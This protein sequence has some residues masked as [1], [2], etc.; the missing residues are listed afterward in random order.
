MLVSH[1]PSRFARW[2]RVGRAP[3][4]AAPSPD[5][6]F[7]EPRTDRSGVCSR[8]VRPRLRTPARRGCSMRV[9]AS[10]PT[11]RVTTAFRA[12]FRALAR[13]FAGVRIGFALGAGAARGFAHIGVLERITE[14]GLPIDAL[15]GLSA[16]AGIGCLWSFGYDGDR[17]EHLV[18]ELQ[19]HGVRWA[20]PTRSLLS[21]RRLER[22]LRHGAAGNGFDEARWPVG[23]VAVDMY[24]QRETLFTMGDLRGACSRAAPYP[25]SI[26]PS[27]STDAGT[28]TAVADPVPTLFVRPLGVDVVV[29]VDIGSAEAGGVAPRGGP[30]CWTSCA[31][32]RDSCTAASASTAAPAQTSSCVRR[33]PSERRGCSAT[34]EDE[35]G[36]VSDAT[37]S[38]LRRTRSGSFYC[39]APTPGTRAT[40]CGRARAPARDP[41][42]TIIRSALRP[43]SSLLRN[44][45][46]KR[47]LERLLEA[48][49]ITL[50]GNG[51]TSVRVLDDRVFHAAATRGLAG[52]RDAY[53]DGWWDAD[54]LDVVTERLLSHRV[55]L[56][57]AAAAE[58][59]SRA[60]L[61][62]APLTGRRRA[63]NAGEPALRARQRPL[64]A[65]CST[66]G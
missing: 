60:A 48:T 25:V 38:T 40:R 11:P 22:H 34:N 3:A 6:A 29:A 39:A 8:S 61:R 23:I 50:D 33:A 54:R 18:A 28:S 17:I 26:L 2:V 19:R 5:S 62:R 32:R 21:G 44:R 1:E 12:R 47:P 43:P 13:D 4:L 45:D 46:V 31:A 49:G 24:A 16:G 55:P 66:A 57:W 59:C 42:R 65:P 58:I 7:L 35:P 37:R 30:S 36:A 52:L 10:A 63:G 14:L 20:L 15:V 56:R 51:P 53:V 27:T 64:R 9:T 41:S